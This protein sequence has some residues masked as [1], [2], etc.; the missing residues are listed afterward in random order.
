MLGGDFF[1]FPLF[2]FLVVFFSFLFCFPFLHLGM[3]WDLAS[4]Y[5]K[6]PF[7]QG[8]SRRS[9]RDRTAAWSKGTLGLQTWRTPVP[10]DVTEGKSSS[11]LGRGTAG[12]GLFPCCSILAASKPATEPLRRIAPGAEGYWRWKRR[13]AKCKGITRLVKKRNCKDIL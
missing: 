8:T 2:L 1:A 12:V 9:A 13:V 5:L 4:K 3:L 10:E 7:S 6:P 11:V